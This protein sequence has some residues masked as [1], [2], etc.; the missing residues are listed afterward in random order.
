MLYRAY[1]PEDPEDFAALY[2]IEEACFQPPL[3][4][5]RAYMRHLVRSSDAAT[6]IAEEDPG[7]MAG[8]AVVEWSGEARARVAYIQT[9]EVAPEKRRLGV[10]AELMRRVEQSAQSAGAAAIWL[11]VDAENASAI[12]LYEAHGYKRK[13]REANFYPRGRAA[14]VYAKPLA[15]PVL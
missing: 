15:A 4:F 8:F 12:R 1:R 13:G 7:Q 3:R 14:L 5:S 11:H 10:G 2:A 6:W 9:I